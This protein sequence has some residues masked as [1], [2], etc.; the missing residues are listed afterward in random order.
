MW[1]YRQRSDWN[2]LT[3]RRLI[4]NLTST[5]SWKGFSAVQRLLILPNFVIDRYPC[6]PS[7]QTQFGLADYLT[8]FDHALITPNGSYFGFCSCQSPPQV[9]CRITVWPDLP[10]TALNL[11]SLS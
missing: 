6:T 3:T 7:P 5:V 10:A 1:A 9:L 11:Y 4:I 2:W 8:P